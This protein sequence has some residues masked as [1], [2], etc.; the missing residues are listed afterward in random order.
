MA[1]GK[2]FSCN[3]VGGKRRESDFYET[4]YSLTRLFLQKQKLW[5][6]ILEPAC[7]GGAIVKVLNES[8][9]QPEAY[10]IE[11]DFFNESRL[12]DWIIT[13]PPYSKA[14]EFI[15]QAKK[16][17]NNFALLLPLS[18]LHGKRRYDEIYSDKE[19]TLNKVYVFT[20]YPMFGEALRDDGKHNTGMMVFAWYVWSRL[21]PS[22]APVIDWLDNQE[23]ILGKEKTEKAPPA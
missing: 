17:S 15:Q 6:S 21:F 5:G 23:F 10:D 8:G 2:N 14:S 16:C 12:F 11:T 1:K 19:F 22:P 9:Y 13:N 7:G 20:R 3:N 18:Y 4:P